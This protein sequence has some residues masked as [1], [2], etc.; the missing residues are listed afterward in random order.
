MNKTFSIQIPII[1]NA[2]P[3]DRQVSNWQIGI[4]LLVIHVQGWVNCNWGWHA[5]GGLKIWF[6]KQ[7]GHFFKINEL[8]IGNG[9]L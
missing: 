4:A 6:S 2:I 7:F 3:L 5:S 1:K 8:E 9:F